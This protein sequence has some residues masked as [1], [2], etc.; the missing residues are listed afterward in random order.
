MCKKNEVVDTWQAPMQNGAVILAFV[1]ELAVNLIFEDWFRVKLVFFFSF[2]FLSLIKIKWMRE[3]DSG[4]G[5]YI[6][7]VEEN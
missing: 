4:G 2:F 5:V 7:C 3:K 6:E 1:N